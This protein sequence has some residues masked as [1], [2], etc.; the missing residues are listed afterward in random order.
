[1]SIRDFKNLGA[2]FF[3]GAFC[4]GGIH[5]IAIRR[6]QCLLLKVALILGVKVV[7]GTTFLKDAGNPIFD[8]E[9][10][11]YYWKAEVDS[12]GKNIDEELLKFNVLIGADGE[13]SSVAEY[14]GFERYYSTLQFSK[15]DN[16]IERYFKEDKLSV[17]LEILKIRRQEKRLLL[18]SLDYWQ[19]INSSSLTN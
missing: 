3:F 5:H 14:Y 6:L 18:M 19:F 4:A 9:K 16:E 17:S 11:C 7:S 12:N 13:N 1:M 15:F 2:K 8:P 10:K